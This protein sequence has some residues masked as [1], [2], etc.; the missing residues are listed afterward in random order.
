MKLRSITIGRKGKGKKEEKGK[1]RPES[2]GIHKAPRRTSPL[3]IVFKPNKLQ[4]ERYHF[5]GSAGLVQNII[6][7]ATVLRTLSPKAESKVEFM[8]NVTIVIEPVRN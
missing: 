3:I 4:K 2:E 8:N 6:Y 5:L 7:T 1:E